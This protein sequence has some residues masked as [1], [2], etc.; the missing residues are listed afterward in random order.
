MNDDMKILIHLSTADVICV[1]LESLWEFFEFQ[2]LSFVY[3]YSI[4]SLKKTLNSQNM[5]IFQ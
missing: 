5:V 1:S 3:L 2:E 4:I